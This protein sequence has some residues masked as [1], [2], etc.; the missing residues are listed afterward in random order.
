MRV[1]HVADYDGPYAGAFVP[2]LRA[3][4]S[5]VRERGWSVEAAFTQ[6]ARERP[7]LADLR[8]DGVPVSIAPGGERRDRDR[9]LAGLAGEGRE[10]AI[11]HTHFK[12]FDMPALRVKRS[13]PGTPVFWHMHQRMR[14]E[15]HGRVLSAV[16]FARAARRV[17]GILCVA[18]EIAAAVQS[19]HVPR[20]RVV[21]LPNAIDLDRFPPRSRARTA[22][23]RRRLG[24]RAG[25]SVVL[26]FGFAWDAREG[27]LLVDA[28]HRLAAGASG[29]IV[30]V[31]VGGGSAARAARD[32]AGLGEDVLRVVEPVEDVTSLYAAADVFVATGPAKGTPF[33]AAEALASGLPVVATDTA[34]HAQLAHRT[35]NVRLALSE[36]DEIAAAVRRSLAT[37]PALA[38]SM[39]AR[40]RARVSEDMDLQAWS[41]RVIGLYERA[42]APLG[43]LS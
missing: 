16:R 5:A 35:G 33:A 9:F 8:A 43:R 40:A 20:D 12:S 21:L 6:E 4:S 41:E 14:E 2:M 18:P 27:E 10:P 25:V 39:A 29:P 38:E 7:W 28:V 17:D 30:A 19:R 23:A 34:G 3:V 42:L 36:S 22:E 32:E 31:S 24:I 15:R 11:I 13:R 26:H 37:R 1:I